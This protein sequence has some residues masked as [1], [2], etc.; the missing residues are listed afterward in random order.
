[1]KRLGLSRICITV[2]WL[3]DQVPSAWKTTSMRHS[4]V[5]KACSRKGLE[6]MPFT[7]L[8]RVAVSSKRSAS[9]SARPLAI[10]IWPR[11]MA[12]VCIT[13]PVAGSQSQ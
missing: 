6:T 13:F 9:G 7:R 1:M 11:G 10:A 12:S 5:V 3:Y 8:P 2:S 4:S